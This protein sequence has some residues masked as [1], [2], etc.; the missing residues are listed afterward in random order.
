M[1]PIRAFTD[2]ATVHLPGDENEMSRRSLRLIERWVPVAMQYYND[3][4]GRRHCGHFFGGVLW[5]GQDTAMT[6]LPLALAASSPE[7][8]EDLAGRTADELLDVALRGLRYLCFTHDTG[9]KDCVRPRESWGR[10]EP[11]G[12]KWGERGRGFFPESQCGRTIAHLAVV[13]ALLGDRISPRERDM[14]AAIAADYLERF[15]EMEPRSGVYA[16]T[17]MEENGWTALGLAASLMLLPGHRRFDDLTERAK[18]W[19]FRAAAMPRDA[20]DRS[21]FAEK[22]T[23]AELCGRCRTMLPDGTVENHG[24]VHPSYLASA[25]TL[26]AATANVLALFGR[27]PPP[28][29]FWHRLDIY[30]TLK[31]WFDGTGASHCVQG[32]DWP[33]VSYP[34]WCLVHAAAAVYLYDPDAPLLERR[35]LDTL[36]RSSAAHA[37]R[38]VPEDTARFCHGQQDP[39]LMR[40]RMIAS[41]AQAYLAH[42]LQ[43]PGPDPPRP[44]DFENRAAGVYVYPHAG[45]LVHRHPHGITSLSWRNR[46]MLLPATREG[47]KLIGPAAGSMLGRIEV[48]DR[49]E[50]T[51]PVA[52]RV[53]E[54]T[55]RACV[56]LL[57]DLAEGS[58]RRQLFFASLPG[59]KC[60]A[61]ERLVARKLVTVS[62]VDQGVL[63]IVNDPYYG[64]HTDR[65]SRRQIFWQGGDRVVYG[66]PLDSD[67]DDV[68]LDLGR[69]GWVNVD[70]RCG[71]VFRGTGRAEYRNRHHFEVWHAIED[72]LVLSRIDTEREFAA[73]EQIA[74]LVTL[75]CPE[76]VHAETARQRL[77]VRPAPQNVFA[78]HADGFLCACN[79][80]DESVVLPEALTFE[81]GWSVPLA[82]GASTRAAAATK[83]PVK[84]DAF[85]PA[86]IRSL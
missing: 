75:W 14:L 74:G 83:T 69:S 53:R 11:A 86:V 38:M 17:Q 27:T 54:G 59:G 5:Y 40:E 57:E 70:D 65:R 48:R 71:L 39:A 33:Y 15:G 13:A 60:L 25:L 1:R 78:A 37:G 52:L 20:R 72:E 41:V 3:W 66:Y 31:P 61:A 62:R 49:A 55:D 35:T 6:L 12:T 84:L 64:E 30:R 73:G 8:D 21:E 24:F 44:L 81:A 16:D 7:F 51:R 46:T 26:S 42:R 29:L 34:A 67:R 22:K 76:Q 79:F 43:G 10:P 23:V 82:W 80:N 9:P 47:M 18:L 85:E 19:M 2:F 68:V 36:E 28:H 50:N 77:A 32:M 4:P 45:A 58:V 56:L 63:S